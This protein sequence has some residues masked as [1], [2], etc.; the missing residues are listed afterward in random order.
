VLHLRIGASARPAVAKLNP[1]L[2]A[3]T[4]A[5]AI[6]QGFASAVRGGEPAATSLALVISAVIKELRAAGANVI[7]GYRSGPRGFVLR[8]ALPRGGSCRGY[9]R[10]CH[11][12]DRNRTIEILAAAAL[13]AVIRTTS[14][15]S[16]SARPEIGH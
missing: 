8:G 9:S 10:R 11:R 7:V 6:N 14:A 2:T 16:N 3:E 5:H 4:R 1:A 13:S 15:G 12:P